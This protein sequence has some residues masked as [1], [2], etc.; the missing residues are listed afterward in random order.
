MI[1]VCVLE[2]ETIDVDVAYNETISVE[3]S[4]VYEVHKNGTNNYDKLNNLPKLNNVTIQGEKTSGDY[5]LFDR[6]NIAKNSDIDKLF[7]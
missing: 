2:T 7:K 5:G 3:T 4:E 6:N 1:E